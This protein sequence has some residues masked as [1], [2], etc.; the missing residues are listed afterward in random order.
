MSGCGKRNPH[1]D[2]N[3]RVPASRRFPH[4]LPFRYRTRSCA[5]CRR[6]PALASRPC[7]PS[8]QRSVRVPR[9]RSPSCADGWP[10]SARPSQVR[11]CAASLTAMASRSTSTRT[12]TSDGRSAASWAPMLSGRCWPTAS[13]QLWA[14][15]TAAVSSLAGRPRTWSSRPA[16]RSAGK[17]RSTARPSLERRPQ[18]SAGNPSWF[19]FLS[20]CHSFITGYLPPLRMHPKGCILTLL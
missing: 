12:P 16:T 8:P 19:P 10:T 14:S 7:V 5:P 11:F 15:P 9:T 17:P 3:Q 6:T 20:W 18:L 4:V 2:V 13:R 1:P